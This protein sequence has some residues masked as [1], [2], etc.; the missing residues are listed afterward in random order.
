MVWYG[1][2]SSFE[3]LILAGWVVDEPGL[4]KEG[5]GTWVVS[6]VVL[7]WTWFWLRPLLL[8]IPLSREFGTLQ[9]N[10]RWTGGG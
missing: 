4:T 9:A 7:V 2:Q 5:Q 1:N 3:A 8:Y 10:K 6:D